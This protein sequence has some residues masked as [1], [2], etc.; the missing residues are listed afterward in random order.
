MSGAMDA[1]LDTPRSTAGWIGRPVAA[2]Q[3]PVFRKLFF[4]ALVGN[5]ASK[6]A[7]LLPGMAPDDYFFAFPVDDNNLLATF[8]AQGRGLNLLIVKGA[9]ALG[10]S[11]VSIQTPALLLALLTVSLFIAAAVNAV[12]E[13]S[14][15]PALPMCAAALAATH[16]Y[17]TSYFLFRMAIIN[18][19][20]AYAVL[21]LA[22]WA[23]SCEGLSARRRF[24]VCTVLLALWCN[25]TQIVLLIFSVVGLAWAFAQG[26]RAREQGQDYRTA[27]RPTAWLIGILVSSAFL[28]FVSSVALRRWMHIHHSAEY[29]PHLAD[30]LRGFITVEGQLAWDLVGNHESMMPLGLKIAF[31]VLLAVALGMAIFRRS[32]WGLAATA[33]LVAGAL[34]TVLPMAVSWRREV[35]RTFSTFGVVLALSL[36]LA[37]NALSHPTSRRLAWLFCPFMLM[38]ALIGGTLFFQQALLTGW[39]QRTA[40]GVYRDVSA[41]GLLTPGRKLK[42]VGPWPNHGQAFSMD[43]SGINESA[44]LYDWTYH[45]LFAVAVGEPVAVAAG[46]PAQCKAQPT[47]PMPGAI[48]LVGPSDVYVCMK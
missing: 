24:V 13:R 3:Q 15:S 39:D 32:S 38:F 44:W 14:A 47:W 37:G 22:T 5:L 7:A 21:F 36:A 31:F 10:L 26:C 41:S 43:G 20:F 29:T 12:A 27:L 2:L 34:I 42:V 45:A 17:L 8:I 9:T 33:V 48:R 23:L 19:A 16:P 30:G 46:D 25:S 4:A 6:L 11:L 18:Q 1:T 35:P 40:A 28:Y